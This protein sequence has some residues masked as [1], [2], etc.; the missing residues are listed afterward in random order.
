[1]LYLKMRSRVVSPNPGLLAALVRTG[2]LSGILRWKVN[3]N[4][5][6]VQGEATQCG[7]TG[8]WIDT[9][10]LSDTESVLNHFA[11]ELNFPDY[12]DCTT[13]AL[14]EFMTDVLSAETKH[15]VVW[16]GWQDYVRAN[17]EH[18][19]EVAQAL[20]FVGVQHNS[21]I[22]VVDSTGDFPDIAELA[23]M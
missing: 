15:F 18:A 13:P 12:F 1:M 9:A 2:N 5:D 4:A 11:Q 17:A 6:V 3:L 10:Q 20:D 19:H 7:W 8:T 14:S 21:P 23:Q 22:F 16:S